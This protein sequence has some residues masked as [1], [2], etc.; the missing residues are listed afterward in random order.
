[1]VLVPICFS[2]LILADILLL[3]VLVY[4]EVQG[5]FGAAKMK[6]KVATEVE[7]RSKECGYENAWFEGSLQCPENFLGVK[8]GMNLL[9]RKQTPPSTHQRQKFGGW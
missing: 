5:G 6:F 9:W 7:A 1:M 8:M 4:C 3:I 2:S